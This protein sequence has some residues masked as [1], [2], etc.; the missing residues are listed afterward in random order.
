VT[1]LAGAR[2]ASTGGGPGASLATD[3]RGVR[4]VRG[5]EELAPEEKPGGGWLA[6]DLRNADG[7][8][9]GGLNVLL[10]PPSDASDA[11]A[12]QRI[13]CDVDVDLYGGTTCTVQRDAAGEPVGR[14]FR[15]PSADG[16]IVTREVTVIGP[17]GAELYA[18]ASNSSDDKWGLGSSTDTTAPALTIAQLRDLISDPTWLDWA[19]PA[20]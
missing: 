5:N 7:D 12:T 17:D 3:G 6:V 2:G 4:G 11:D 19:P 16:V 20:G 10:Y 8:P 1:G 18:A 15:S 9:V 14:T 13:S